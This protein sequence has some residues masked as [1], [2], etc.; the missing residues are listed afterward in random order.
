M[1]DVDK[2]YYYQVQGYMWLMGKKWARI[3]YCLVNTPDYII[4]SEQNRLLYSMDVV[5]R[6]SPAFQIAAATLESTMKFDHIHPK[7]RVINHYVYR[8]EEIIE[9]IPSKVEKARE[10]LQ[11]VYEKHMN[12]VKV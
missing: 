8:D 10:F 7:Y 2:A 4:L 12:L 11:E 9:K 6:E 1:E 5:S 3:S